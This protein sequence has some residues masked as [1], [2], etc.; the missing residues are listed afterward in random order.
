M[1][2]G[3]LEVMVMVRS[4]QC[5]INHVADVANATDLRR[6]GGEGAPKVEKKNFQRVSSRVI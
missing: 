5:R 3:S 2:I 6:Q 1:L 4:G